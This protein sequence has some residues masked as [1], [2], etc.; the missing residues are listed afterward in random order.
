MALR[1]SA[2]CNLLSS[3]E[4]IVTHDPPLLPPEGRERLR[5]ETKDWFR[6]HRRAIDSLDAASTA[7]LLSC[8]FPERRTGRVY[9]LQAATLTRLLSRTLG[10]S[11]SKS[12]NLSAYRQPGHGDLGNCLERVLKDGGPPAL[13]F[14]T[15]EEVDTVLIKL[16]RSCHFS[17]PAL[18]FQPIGDSEQHRLSLAN[19]FRRLHPSEAKWLVRLI[20]KDFAP[21]RLEETVVLRSVHFLLPDILRFQQDFDAAVTTLRGPFKA[22]PSCPDPQSG[23]LLR[24]LV[25]ASFRPTLGIKVARSEFCKARSIDQCMKIANGR[26]WML[27]RK[28]DGEYCEIHIDLSKK[29][30]WLKIFSK[31]GKDSTADR[32]ALHSTLRKCLQIGTDKCK[33]KER[34]ILLGEM[35][36]YSDHE[37]QILP[38]HKIRKHVLRSG[39]SLGTY[40][41]SQPHEWEHLMIV[42]FDMLL[43]DDNILMHKPLEER[44]QLLNSIYKKRQGRAVTAESKVVDFAEPDA[45]R[46]L[47]AHLA[48]SVAAR[49]EGLVVKPCGQPY[50]ALANDEAGSNLPV[51]KLK[52]DY[53]AGL[54]DE[55]DFAV[56]GASY[57]AQESLQSSGRQR[58]FTHFHLGCLT[59]KQ[60]VERF[61]ARPRFRY[62]ATIALEQCIPLPVLDKASNIMR[63]FGKPYRLDT[64]PAAFDLAHV[65][66]VRI[67]TIIDEPFVF[68]VLGSSFDK[69]SNTDFW[70]LRHPRVK[71]LHEDRTWKDCISFQELQTMAQEAVTVP[72]G[73]E[74]Q[75]NIRWMD[76]I[77]RSCRRKIARASNQTTPATKSTVSPVSARKKTPLQEISSNEVTQRSPTAAVYNSNSRKRKASAAGLESKGRSSVRFVAVLP[78][79]PTS[80]PTRAGMQ[81]VLSLHGPTKDGRQTNIVDRPADKFATSEDISEQVTPRSSPAQID[82]REIKSTKPVHPPSIELRFSSNISERLHNSTL[83]N[84]IPSKRQTTMT[85][86]S[87]GPLNTNT[88]AHH[89]TIHSPEMERDLSALPQAPPSSPIGL[90]PAAQGQCAYL[91]HATR[92]MHTSCV[93]SDTVVYIAVEATASESSISRHAAIA[94]VLR[95][96][97]AIITPELAHWNRDSFAYT[98][99]GEVVSESQSHPG[100]Q[101]IVVLDYLGHRRFTADIVAQVK[102]LNDGKF[103]ER[104]EFYHFLGLDECCSHI[105]IVRKLRSIQAPT[106][107]SEAKEGEPVGLIDLGE[108]RKMN[109]AFQHKDHGQLTLMSGLKAEVH[110]NLLGC[111]EWDTEMQE[112]VWFDALSGRGGLED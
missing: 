20:L 4:H 3:L 101:K 105:N 30:D 111:L 102:A 59:N 58:S 24:K 46:K 10:L 44:K 103:R 95:A 68:E 88:D 87:L 106:A 15:I 72:A 33:I 56:I 66:G 29:D 2:L 63:I 112:S 39:V 28:Y 25:S 81:D 73:S 9:G 51:I 70:M 82:S 99:L 45:R 11:A 54:G 78:T 40:K 67:D 104:V 37:K 100:L 22:Y 8:L 79:P 31:S 36:V 71:K 5:L 108:G 86:G 65:A 23:S 110:L 96:H 47:M 12:K 21:V 49:H 109:D 69:A 74:S 19:I 98:L 75:E 27:E 64:Q 55:A 50:F 93:L 6:S 13:P 107:C 80:S 92:G 94:D 42:F 52:K 89:M 76:K 26:R 83:T 60:D 90:P 32:K 1:F 38:F 48:A 61:Q 7:A 77:E 41:D 35:V 53:I 57:R 84:N 62:V 97:G 34:C 16:A 85:I 17:D 43:I 18:R 91:N 14:V